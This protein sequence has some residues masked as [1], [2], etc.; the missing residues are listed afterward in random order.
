M[1]DFTCRALC[2]C[3][4]Y[5]A[6]RV[7]ITCHE[8]FLEISLSFA[9]KL[10][11]FY[12]ASRLGH[13]VSTQWESVVGIKNIGRWGWMLETTPGVLSVSFFCGMCKLVLTLNRLFLITSKPVLKY[14][15]LCRLYAKDQDHWCSVQCLQ[16]WIGQDKNISKELYCSDW[17][18]SFQ[19]VVWISLC[20]SSWSEEGCQAGMSLNYFDC[21]ILIT[22]AVYFCAFSPFCLEQRTEQH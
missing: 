14:L 16:Q 2:T 5:F 7:R 3:C 1:H 12:S 15:S 22:T 6:P 21:Y 20:H 9:I 10:V 11:T 4:M 17:Q 13:V 19:A 8:C 18:H